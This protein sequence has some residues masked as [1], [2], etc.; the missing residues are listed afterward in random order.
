MEEAA[1]AAGRA[2]ALAESGDDPEAL[3]DALHARV[4]VLE[5]PDDVAERVRLVDRIA[6]WYVPEVAD[7]LESLPDRAHHGTARA[8]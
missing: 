1:E 2:L 7:R 3:L 8:T 6:A 4:T 5:C